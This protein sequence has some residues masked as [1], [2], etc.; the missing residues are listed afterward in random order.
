MSQEASEAHIQTYTAK[1]AHLLQQRGSKL[2]PGVMTESHTGKAAQ[3]VQQ[4]GAVEAQEIT[5]RHADTELSDTPQ[6]SRWVRPSDWGVADMVDKEDLVRSLTDPKSDFA[7]AQT[8]GL[9]RKQDDILIA[10]LLGSNFIGEDGGTSVS[11]SS[12]GVTV[13]VANSQGLTVEK[14]R[15]AKKNLMAAEVDLDHDTLYMALTAEQIDNLYTETQVVSIDYNSNKVLVDGRV[16]SFMGWN[17]LHC[18]RLTVN[19]SSERRCIGWAK[20]GVVFASWNGLESHT[21]RRPDKWN[22]WQVMTKGTFGATRTEGEK[23]VEVACM[24]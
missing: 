20:S 2:M 9:G 10:A 4:Y 13:V 17:F 23:V 19:G 8:M 21:D 18:E 7:M 24:E 14:L 11:A 15:E 5:D 22:N 16:Q 3:V 6:T 12:D 1:V